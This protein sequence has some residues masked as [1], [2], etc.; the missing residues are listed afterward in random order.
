MVFS[1][2]CTHCKKGVFIFY[3]LLA[4]ELLLGYNYMSAVEQ[5]KEPLEEFNKLLNSWLESRNF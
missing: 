1:S 5:I 4:Q 2:F 3:S